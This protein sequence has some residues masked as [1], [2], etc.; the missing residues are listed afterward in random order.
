MDQCTD[1]ATATEQLFALYKDDVY[2]YAR[3][4][5]GSASDAE[6]VVQEVFIKVLRSWDRF[7]GDASPK[8]WLWTI[9]RSCI[10]DRT[11][12][13][14]SRDE[15][16]FDESIGG[17]TQYQEHSGIELEDMLKGLPKD[18]R[19]VIVLRL[20]QDWSTTDTAKILKW[21]ESKVKT[22]L[23][24]SVSK[25]RQ[26]LGDESAFREGRVHGQQ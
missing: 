18:Y 21:S 11:R 6:D 5:L 10:V 4:T 14:N 20:L 15:M 1:A 26:Q 13:R 2:R 7:R 22:T 8:T 25:L 12:K 23:H 24:R 16:P 17:L 9:V 3:F 19:E